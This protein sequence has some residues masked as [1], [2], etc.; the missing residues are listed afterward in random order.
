MSSGIL[1]KLKTKYRSTD[2]VSILFALMFLLLA[3]MVAVTILAASTTTAKR[4]SD[5]KARTQDYLALRSAV[6]YFSQQ[7]ADTTVILSYTGFEEAVSGSGIVTNNGPD[8]FVGIDRSEGPLSGDYF[9][10]VYANCIDH[11]EASGSYSIELEDPSSRVP[12]T[13]VEFKMTKYPS[14]D[15]SGDKTYI[16]GYFSV[17]GSTKDVQKIY[18]FADIQLND[19]VYEEIDNTLSDAAYDTYGNQIVTV[20][21]EKELRWATF[22]YDSIP[23]TPEL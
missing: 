16:S 2:G 15:P 7:L 19:P 4:I 14:G 21:Y 11:D 22:Q 13:D 5:D 9:E 17:A 20:Y 10:T 23:I 6:E 12:K 3:S 1:Q 18:F 8:T